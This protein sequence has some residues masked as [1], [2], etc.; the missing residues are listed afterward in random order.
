MISEKVYNLSSF[1][2]QYKAILSLSVSSTI[3][4]LIWQESKVELQ[5]QIN[6][7]NILGIASILSYS[8]NSEHLDAALRISQTCLIS[9][10]T[11]IQKAGAIV[12]LET[13]TNIPAL[14]LAVK[15]RLIP[16]NY[17]QNLP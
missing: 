1:K 9:E 16:D 14:K 3:E 4:S 7:N 10:T 8:E 12:I 5:K 17:E 15:R 6:W 11:H 13:L 2:I